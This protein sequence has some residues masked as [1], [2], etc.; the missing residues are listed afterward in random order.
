MCHFIDNTDYKQTAREYHAN[1]P[2][3]ALISF[4]NAEDFFTDSDESYS[5]V[6]ISVEANIQGWAMDYNGLYNSSATTA[7]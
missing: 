4:D 5:N 7:T 1:M 6:H 2:A 3:V